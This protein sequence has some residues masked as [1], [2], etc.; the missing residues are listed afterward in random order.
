MSCRYL[1]LDYFNKNPDVPKKS[2]VACCP[3]QFYLTEPALCNHYIALIFITGF[4]SRFYVLP[5][6]LLDFQGSCYF[7]GNILQHEGGICEQ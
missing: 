3:Y 1:A 5:F 6:Q 2:H 4:V 7:P